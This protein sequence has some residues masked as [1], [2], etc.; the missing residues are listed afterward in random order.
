MKQVSYQVPM[1][2]TYI[3]T[4]AMTTAYHTVPI[5]VSDVNNNLMF[6]AHTINM[7]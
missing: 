6:V 7:E 1:H 4:E 5:Y 2:C 3:T